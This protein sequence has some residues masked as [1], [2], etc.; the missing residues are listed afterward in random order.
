MTQPLNINYKFT[1]DIF[2]HGGGGG[3]GG[4]LRYKI[5]YIIYTI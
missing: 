5:T 1:A 3:G 2:H 4:G